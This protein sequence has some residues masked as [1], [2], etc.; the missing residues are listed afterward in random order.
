MCPERFN[1]KPLP[2]TGNV[3]PNP[4][5]NITA[6]AVAPDN[7]VA[8][9]DG[10]YRTVIRATKPLPGFDGSDIAVASV[11][12]SALYCD[13]AGLLVSDRNADGLVQTLGETATA[14]TKRVTVSKGSTETRT[15]VTESLAA[16]AYHDCD[17]VG[18][19]DGERPRWN[20]RDCGHRGGPAVRHAGTDAADRDPPAHGLTQTVRSARGVSLATLSDPLSLTAQTDEIVENNLPSTT[21]FEVVTRSLT[22]RSGE[23]GY[24]YRPWIQLDWGGT[25]TTSAERCGR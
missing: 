13:A 11:G 14:T 16:G 7:V 10:S 8:I 3:L 4:F 15:Y 20:E 9:R 2:F 18:H 21:T 24:P 5:L 23:G 12:V 19:H 6:L 22:E 1:L 25:R 17:C